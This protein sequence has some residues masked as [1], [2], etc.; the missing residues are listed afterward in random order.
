VAGRVEIA[1]AGP[2]VAGGVRDDALRILLVD[3]RPENLSALEA[4]LEPLGLPL[5]TANSG[6]QALRLLLE[7]DYAVILLDV[8]MPGLDGLE[9][10]R[11]IKGRDRTRHVPIVFLTAAQDDVSDIMRGYEAGA[12]D[13]VL[14]PFDA[15][16][17]RSKVT[18]LVELQASRRALQRSEELL[19]GAFDSSPTGMTVLDQQH[20][21]VRANQAFGAFLQRD[22][23]SLHGLELVELCDRR[24]HRTLLSALEEVAGRS[25]GDAPREGDGIPLRMLSLGGAE[26]PLA[27]LA[28]QLAGADLGEPLLLAQW[29]D[30][31][32]RRRAE[33]ARA[34]LLLEQSARS[35]AEARAERLRKLQALTEALGSPSLR[36]TLETLAIR[37]SELFE[38]EFSEVRFGEREESELVFRASSGRLLPDGEEVAAAVGSRQ[39]VPLRIETGALGSLALQLPPARSLTPPEHALLL[40]VAEQASISIRR[41]QLY[42]EEHRIAV[43]LQRGLLPKRLPSVAGIQLSAHYEAAGRT[44]EVGGDWYDAFELPGGRLGLVVGDVAGRGIPAASTMGQ[45]RS[46]TRAFAVADP[47]P[48]SPGEVLSRLNHY[49][50]ALGEEQLFTV[51]YAILDAGGGWLRWANAG[52]LPPLVRSPSGIASYLE[53]TGLPMGIDD[54]EYETRET[55]LG[56]GGGFVLYTDGL[57]ERR[58]EQIDVGLARLADAVRSGPAD[59][60]ELVGWALARAL[61]GHDELHDD[62]TLVVARV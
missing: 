17:L 44:A 37:I 16:V 55:P 59:P 57:V 54:V 56:R 18:I 62:V 60:D 9:T 29:V 34:E 27:L 41:A 23:T 2:L 21:I 19:R 32:A 58:D 31:T 51:V 38:C 6:H 28:T 49:Q 26:V 40:D 30:L 25:P 61:A 3:D 33:Q 13:Y 11:L 24:D 47:H 46:V 14:K 42:E 12:V 20:R 52:H 15:D 48:H 50:L 35:E 36:S 4:V 43:E 5:V 39:E 53:G 22:A 8:R 10:A 7:G 1:A 45:L